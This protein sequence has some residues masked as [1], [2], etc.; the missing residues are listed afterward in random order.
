MLYLLYVL[1]SLL[2]YVNVSPYHTWQ[3][4]KHRQSVPLHEVILI[5]QFPKDF[6]LLQTVLQ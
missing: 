2:I 5:K 4:L 6:L 1:L 3:S